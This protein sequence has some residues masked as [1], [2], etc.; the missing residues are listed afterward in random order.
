MEEG[1]QPAG[2]RR[3]RERHI[4]ELAGP[5][6]YWMTITDAAR[7]TRRQDITLRRWIAS[8]ELPVRENRVGLNRRARQVRASD[9]A[10]LTPIIDTSAMISGEEAYINLTSIPTEQATIRADHQRLLAEIAALREALAYQ[11]AATEQALV[12]QQ[13]SWQQAFKSAQETAAQKLVRQQRVMEVQQQEHERI[14]ADL[15]AQLALHTETA[16]QQQQ[17]LLATLQ[18]RLL[19]QKNQFQVML[20]E[21]HQALEVLITRQSEHF[22][23]EIE[24]FVRALA[25][26]RQEFASSSVAFTTQLEQIE[27]TGLSRS[28]QQA[29]KIQ[30]LRQSFQQEQEGTTQQIAL[31]TTQLTEYRFHQAQALQKIE[32]QFGHIRCKEVDWQRDQADLGQRVT[33]LTKQLAE[34]RLLQDQALR[35]VKDQLAHQHVSFSV[36]KQQMEEREE[37]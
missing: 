4:E 24:A 21:Q 25:E 8:G 20:Q 23:Q 6:D 37:V 36:L 29:Q 16:Q 26:I 22:E 14:H 28:A 7:A 3:T 17:Q 13:E 34:H 27:Q 12:Q 5:D 9:V 19:A 1:V 11:Q 15:L 10:R 31:L 35:L 32:D 2:Q 30:Q 33:V 18:E